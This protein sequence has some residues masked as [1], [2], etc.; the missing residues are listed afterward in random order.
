QNVRFL[1][2]YPLLH[3][4]TQVGLFRHRAQDDQE[5]DASQA[6][7]DQEGVAQAYAR[8]RRGNRSL[9]EA[10][11]ARASELLCRL[12]SPPEHVVVLQSST[13]ALAQDASATKPDGRS[14]LG[15]LHPPRRTLLSANQDTT[16]AALSSLRRQNPREEPGA[17]A[18]LAGD[19]GGGEEQSS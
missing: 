1:G 18:A 4:I 2:L 15:A 6:Q 5:A 17:L 11:A 10:D 16:P 12:G 7:G 19:L 8:P 14:L 9:G 3:A 13:V